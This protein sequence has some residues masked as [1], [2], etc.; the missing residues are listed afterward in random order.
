MWD[1][2]HAGGR[3][4]LCGLAARCLIL[5]LL[6][7]AGSAGAAPRTTSFVHS[8]G[9]SFDYPSKWSVK[10]LDEG[11]LLTPHDAGT[12]AGGRPLEVIVIGFVGASAGDPFEP[13][14]AD[15]FVRHYR[16]LV[17]DLMRVGDMD[18]LETSIGLG[19]MVP[20]KDRVGNPHRVYCA[21]HGQLGI[22]LAHVTRSDTVRSR[23]DLV[24][25]IFSSFNWTDSLVDPALV[26]AW[27][28]PP[29]PANRAP[30]QEATDTA[31]DRWIFSDDGRLRRANIEPAGGFYSSSRGVLNIV[32]DHGLEESYRYTVSPRP[33]GGSQ[34]ELKSPAGDAL[35]L[36]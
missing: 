13:S 15:A 27:D 25:K 33:E 32:W 9:F 14:F 36:H 24:G 18:W 34:L 6:L 1:R 21:V 28:A 35:H 19:L 12:D 7:A 5:I 4:H 3:R 2:S 8:V 11:L 31:A 16:S 29:E 20:F 23:I 10:R 26:R 30:A 22:F 17:P